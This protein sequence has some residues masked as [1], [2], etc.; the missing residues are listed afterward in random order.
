MDK[1]Q[2]GTM[3]TD[4]FN[5]DNRYGADNDFQFKGRYY[6]RDPGNGLCYLMEPSADRQGFAVAPLV[7]RRVSKE[8]YTE[9]LHA[10]LDSI[11]RREAAPAP[12][13]PDPDAGL[14]FPASGTPLL[15]YPPG[16][17][18]LYEGSRQWA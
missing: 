9:A 14:P 18:P 2:R 4:S 6:T 12:P 11:A 5:Q 16:K 15:R 7:R 1:E 10:L 3:M 17:G 8:T 13:D